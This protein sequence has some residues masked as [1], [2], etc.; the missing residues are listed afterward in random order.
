MAVELRLDPGVVCSKRQGRD[1]RPILED[2]THAAASGDGKHSNVPAE[3][4]LQAIRRA[5]LGWNVDDQVD[6]RL[7]GSSSIASRTRLPEAGSID[8]ATAP[9]Q[10]RWARGRTR[11]YLRWG[12][13]TRVRGAQ[14]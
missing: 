6:A 2:H 9:R 7:W 4:V 1:A 3:V 14:T 5:P 13:S 8:A 12:A 10:D 11:R